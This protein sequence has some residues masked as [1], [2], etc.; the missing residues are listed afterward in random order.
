MNN[1]NLL[2]A[3]CL[4]LGVSACSPLLNTR[5]T[6][7]PGVEIT[8]QLRTQIYEETT[9]ALREAVEN[10]LVSH[11][12]LVEYLDTHPI[13]YVLLEPDSLDEGA[14]YLH[15]DRTSIV[16]RKDYRYAVLRHEVYHIALII[17]GLDPRSH[18]RI[19][20][21]NNWCHGTCAR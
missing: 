13:E 8:D 2:L 16:L 6:F 4:A 7:Y 14:V 10:E 18:H 5:I 11:D 17:S 9:L 15:D 20:R 19:M 12:Q 3:T 21:T 1:K